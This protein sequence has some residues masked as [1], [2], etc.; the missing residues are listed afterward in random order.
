MKL[1]IITV[2][3]NAAEDLKTTLSSLSKLNFDFEL[4]IVDGFS[5]DHTSTVVDEFAR[6]VSKFISEPD[7]GIYDAMNKGVSNATGDVVYFLNA[8]DCIFDDVFFLEALDYFRL[9]SDVDGVFGNIIY[10]NGNIVRSTYGPKILLH[11]TIHHQSIIYKRKVI[12]DN[13]FQL[14]FKILADYYFNLDCY[15]KKIK[16]K[17]IDH[18]AAICDPC[19]VSRTSINKIRNEMNSV[20]LSIIGNPASFFLKLIFNVKFWLHNV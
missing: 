20:R 7:D 18:I 8:G 14:E 4:I 9:D 19:G 1:S 17:K 13:P 3:F 11:N 15:I 2:C 6:Y 12:M 16:F 5:K 10:T